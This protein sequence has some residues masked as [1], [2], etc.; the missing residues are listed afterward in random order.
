MDEYEEEFEVYDR[1]RERLKA[2]RRID[3]VV[4]EL[5]KIKSS[6]KYYYAKN[7]EK[8]EV[9]IDLNKYEKIDGMFRYGYEVYKKK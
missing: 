2:N 4:Y 6:L 1:K 9:V 8:Q 3:E 5:V 7:L